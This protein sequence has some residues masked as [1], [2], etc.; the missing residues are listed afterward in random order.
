[1]NLQSQSEQLSSVVVTNK[2]D[3]TTPVF[4][5]YR[6]V[7]PQDGT[8]IGTNHQNGDSNG[9]LNMNMNRN[10]INNATMKET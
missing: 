2:N 1:M 10:N 5:F 6:K 4:V 7:R 9:N 8:T 3:I